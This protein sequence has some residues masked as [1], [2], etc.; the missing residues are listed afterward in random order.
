MSLPDPKQKWLKKNHSRSRQFQRWN[1]LV[2]LRNPENQIWRV[3]FSGKGVPIS[4]NEPAKIGFAIF[5]CIFPGRLPMAEK[6]KGLD[7]R[8]AN[9]TGEHSDSR[10]NGQPGIDETIIICLHIHTAKRSSS[11]FRGPRPNFG[12][13]KGR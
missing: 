2:K 6:R 13:R 7:P 3:H 11:A 1:L 10:K 5:F 9:H 4:K 8:S 12:T